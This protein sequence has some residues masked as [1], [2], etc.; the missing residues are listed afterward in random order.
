MPQLLEKNEINLVNGHN[1]I[2]NGVRWPLPEELQYKFDSY[3][4]SW[5]GEQ[6][7]ENS[8]IFGHNLNGTQPPLFGFFKDTMSVRSW[9]NILE[10]IS[11]SM[12]CALVI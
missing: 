6:T 5:K 9:L 2:V 1:N 4:G 10:R 3:L 12:V 7:T 8:M 11:H